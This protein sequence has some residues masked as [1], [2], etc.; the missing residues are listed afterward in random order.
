MILSGAFLARANEITSQVAG[1]D[2][3]YRSVYYVSKF[4][5]WYLK[6]S[7]AREEVMKRVASLSSQMSNVRYMLRLFGLLSTIEG[8]KKDG[9]ACGETD[10]LLKYIAKIQTWSMMLYYPLE[11]MYWLSWQGIWPTKYGD[12]FSLWSCRAWVVYI[13]LDMI[14]D[15]YRLCRLKTEKNRVIAIINSRM[16]KLSSSRTPILSSLSDTQEIDLNNQYQSQLARIDQHIWVIYVKIGIN[17]CDLPLA[18]TWSLR[19]D[20]LPLIPTA[21]FGTISS[22]VGLYLKWYR[23]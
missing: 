5:L 4:I 20:P 13:L 3:I 21:L 7:H 15:S 1:A 8:L 19:S 9:G 11:H 6:K 14:G 2:K 18:V 22:S 10:H 23:K 16:S 12:D 17:L